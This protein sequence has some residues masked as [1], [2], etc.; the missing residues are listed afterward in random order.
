MVT[1]FDVL[2]PIIEFMISCDCDGGL[3]ID[4]DGSGGRGIESELSE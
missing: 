3:V 2:S 1:D 4:M